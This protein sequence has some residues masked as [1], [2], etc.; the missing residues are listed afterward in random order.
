MSESE[1][2]LYLRKVIDALQERFVRLDKVY[3]RE[4]GEMEA[5]LAEAKA[6]MTKEY[7]RLG[8]VK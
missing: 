8:H 4:A 5:I 6:T 2:I 7:G 3:K 1:D